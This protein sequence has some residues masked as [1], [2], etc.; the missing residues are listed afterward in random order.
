MR[1]QTQAEQVIEAMRQ[2]GGYAEFGR[3]N[4]LIDFSSWKTKSPAASVRRIVQLNK[5]FYRIQPGLWALKERRREVEERLRLKA[6]DKK[7]TGIFTHSYYQGLVT[8]IG[9]MKN[10]QTYVPAQDKNKLFLETPLK[11]IAGLSRIYNFTYP[12][13]LRRVASVDVIWFNER[14]LPDSFFEIEHSTTM[15]NSLSKFCM[16]RDYFARFVIVAPK[17]KRNQ[18]AEVSADPLFAPIRNRV[19]F[20]DYDTISDQY[21]A[22][23]KLRGI[24]NKI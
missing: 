6:R 7:G 4:R 16:V 13:I 2:N 5:A 18:F 1:T 9:N 20:T 12:E 19:T 22:L 17:F 11:N 14:N 3:L 21:A 15:R 10:M 24:P 23:F 8:E